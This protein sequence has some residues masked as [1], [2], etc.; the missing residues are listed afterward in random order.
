[1]GVILELV[2]LRIVGEVERLE[3]CFLLRQGVKLFLKKLD[4]I[5][6]L[7]DIFIKF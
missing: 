6:Q 5:L 4:I 1:M 3:C 2:F 7:T